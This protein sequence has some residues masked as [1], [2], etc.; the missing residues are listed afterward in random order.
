MSD[1]LLVSTRKGL[2]VLERGGKGW[3]IARKSFLGDNVALTAVDPRD[4]AWYAVLDLGHFGNKLQRSMDRGFI[5]LLFLT[6]ITGLVLMLVKTTA[7]LP[8]ASVSPMTTVMI[9]ITIA[10]GKSTSR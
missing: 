3:Q 5:V 10:S 7:A 9:S 4:G 1:T 8:L 2:F 6:G